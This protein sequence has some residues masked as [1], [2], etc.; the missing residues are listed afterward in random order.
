[1]GA[2]LSRP[3][4]YAVVADDR[5]RCATGVHRNQKEC[6]R[7]GD[8]ARRIRQACGRRILPVAC[9]NKIIPN[10]RHRGPRRAATNG[11]IHYRPNSGPEHGLACADWESVSAVIIQLR[12]DSDWYLGARGEWKGRPRKPD[13]VHR[14]R[15]CHKHNLRSPLVE[16]GKRIVVAGQFIGC[17]RAGASRMDRQDRIVCEPASVKCV[18]RKPNVVTLRTL[19]TEPH[20]LARARSVA[21]G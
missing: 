17:C 20:V 12:E 2:R 18:D 5:R 8:I 13:P 19:Y 7:R 16:S 11:W 6:T 10:V 4:D 21:G 14:V 3:S 15:L 1:M 9:G